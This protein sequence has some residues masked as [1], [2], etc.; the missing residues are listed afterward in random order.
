[1]RSKFV[2]FG[3]GKVVLLII[4]FSS[5]KSK[6][7]QIVSLFLGIIKVRAA[8]PELFLGFNTP[9]L[10]NLSTFDLEFLYVL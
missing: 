9:I 8:H 6:I 2:F 4:L 7:K 3:F 10:I 1:M 5:L